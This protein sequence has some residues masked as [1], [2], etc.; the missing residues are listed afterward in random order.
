MTN[1]VTNLI[2][3]G[4]AAAPGLAL[5][6]EPTTGFFKK[7]GGQLGIAVA[8]V[9]V[10]ELSANGLLGGV[11]LASVTFQAAGA[12]VFT[13]T[14]P[15][16]AGARIIDIGVDGK[17]LWNAATSASIIVGDDVDPDGF[18]TA[19]DLKATDLLAGEINNLEHPGG[20]AGAYIASEQ[21]QL[22]SASARNIVGVVT[23][24]GSGNTGTT[25]MYVVYGVAKAI[26]PV[27][28]S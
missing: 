26:A 17:T 28:T 19:T 22:Q 25:I 27:T 9:E 3:D 12:H 7:G 18:F 21:R 20:K 16:P 14:I 1:V 2:P 24:V 23:Q 15:L 4:I 5:E 8:G 11:N 10:G 6:S 13:G